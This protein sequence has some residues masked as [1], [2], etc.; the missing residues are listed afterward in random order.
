MS[1]ILGLGLLGGSLSTLTVCKTQKDILK[2]TFSNDLDKK[3]E[4]IIVERRNHYIMGL[5]IGMCLS[6][7]V[8]NSMVVANK[9]TRITLFIAITLGTAFIFYMVMPK[10]DYMLN[11]LRTPEEN[12]KW[13]EVHK[14]MKSRYYMG[15]ILGI[16]ATIP[17]ARALC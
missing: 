6:Y 14:M 13:L 11:H 1:G 17:L 3:Y 10:S 16:V 2:R 5:V 9:F 8:A 7:L 4:K 12:K 15:F